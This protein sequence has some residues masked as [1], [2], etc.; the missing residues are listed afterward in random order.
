MKLGTIIKL[1]DNQ[2]AT[3]CYNGLDGVGIILGEHHLTNEE[4]EIFKSTTGGL[5]SD[6]HLQRQFRQKWNPQFLLRKVEDSKFTD[7]PCIGVDYDIIGDGI[8]L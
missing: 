7:I 2:L 1:P 6:E 3:I 4:I 8:N 5:F